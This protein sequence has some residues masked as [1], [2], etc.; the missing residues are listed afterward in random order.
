MARSNENISASALLFSDFIIEKVSCN[1]AEFRPNN[2]ILY[3]FCFDK[4]T[5]RY[6]PNPED[7]PVIS[8]VGNLPRDIV[9]VLYRCSFWFRNRFPVT[10]VDNKTEMQNVKRHFQNVNAELFQTI[11]GTAVH[12]INCLNVSEEGNTNKQFLSSVSVYT[13]RRGSS[14]QFN[15]KPIHVLS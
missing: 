14:I 7:A 11:S 3:L 8:A 12:C 2:A 15:Q 5:A 1:A 4:C 13:V 9:L 10:K 6:R